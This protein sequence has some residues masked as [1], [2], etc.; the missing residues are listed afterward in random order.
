MDHILSYFALLIILWLVAKHCE[1]EW[2]DILYLYFLYA[3][4]VSIFCLCILLSFVLGWGKLITVWHFLILL[5][6]FF[7]KNQ[8]RIWFRA[9]WCHSWDN[10]LLDKLPYVPWV[11][12]ILLWLVGTGTWAGI[13]FKDYSFY[14][15]RCPLPPTAFSSF[16]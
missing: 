3:Y 2:W 8:R 9:S 5:S 7:W 10:T 16:L 12:M 11:M 6:S 13:K 1:F 15:F 4:F 14:F